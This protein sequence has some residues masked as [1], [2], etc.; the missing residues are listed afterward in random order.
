MF[1]Y[2]TC[3]LPMGLWLYLPQGLKCLGITEILKRIQ[4]FFKYSVANACWNL[5]NAASA[6]YEVIYF[7]LTL[8]I[9]HHY[10]LNLN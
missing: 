7:F 2:F 6:N 1:M 9:M 8:A 10:Y 3:Y 4:K 5:P